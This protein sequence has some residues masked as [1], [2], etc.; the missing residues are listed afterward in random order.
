MITDSAGDSY[1]D[2]TAHAFDMKQPSTV[3]YAGHQKMALGAANDNE[4]PSPFPDVGMQQ[5]QIDVSKIKEYMGILPKKDNVVPFKKSENKGPVR[6]QEM[7][8]I[9]DWFSKKPEETLPKGITSEPA[10]EDKDFDIVLPP[11]KPLNRNILPEGR[12][13]C[14]IHAHKGGYGINLCP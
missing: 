11:G 4:P 2:A 9:M 6:D 7:A 8:G 13:W 1:E 12:D 10:K 5:M 14:E 3:D